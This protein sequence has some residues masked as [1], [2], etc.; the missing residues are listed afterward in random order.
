M[1]DR[2][3]VGKSGSGHEACGA[4]AIHAA[5]AVCA[6]AARRLRPLLLGRLYP[7][8]R[9]FCEDESGQSITEYILILSASV[10]GAGLVSRQVLKALDTGILKLGGQLEKDLKTGRASVGIWQN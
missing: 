2:R 3:A 8:V 9:R 7:A 6:S 5:R 1:G 4:G 10:V